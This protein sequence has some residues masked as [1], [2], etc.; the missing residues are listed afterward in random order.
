MLFADLANNLNTIGIIFN[1]IL[2][3]IEN[4]L[5]SG[6]EFLQICIWIYKD[7]DNPTPACLW[8]TWILDRQ[9]KWVI[10]MIRFGQ[11]G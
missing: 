9:W 10:V 4:M 8:N 11:L 3:D 5:Y 1:Q 6:E 2:L 7:E